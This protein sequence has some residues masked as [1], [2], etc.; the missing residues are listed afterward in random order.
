MLF[1][2]PR[3]SGLVLLECIAPAPHTHICH[4]QSACMLVPRLQPSPLA[5]RPTPTLRTLPSDPPLPTP[6]PST[7]GRRGQ[8]QSSFAPAH[9]RM[10]A[11]APAG[12]HDNH[13]SVVWSLP[14]RFADVRQITRR[15]CDLWHN[16]M[17]ASVGALLCHE[18]NYCGKVI[19]CSSCWVSH[20]N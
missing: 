7:T 4:L 13:G 8:S 12:C 3:Y 17:V 14:R 2:W 1:K 15:N 5:P 9:G 19:V 18:S 20:M 6:P 10:S 16:K 11:P